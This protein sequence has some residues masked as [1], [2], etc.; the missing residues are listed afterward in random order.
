MCAESLLCSHL[1]AS[2][3]KSHALPAPVSHKT[4]NTLCRRLFSFSQLPYEASLRFGG[5]Q[6]PSTSFFQDRCLALN[7]QS[8]TKA[9]EYMY[10]CHCTCAQPHSHFCKQFSIN[11]TQNI[12]RG[13]LSGI[14]IYVHASDYYSMLYSAHVIGTKHQK[15]ANLYFRVSVRLFVINFCQC[16]LRTSKH[17]IRAH[18]SLLQQLCEKCCI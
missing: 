15:A 1:S 9:H 12:R 17:T 18:A 8:E 6:S 13:G 11:M 14:V 10:A 4:R 3:P 2:K 16:S 7:L 5:L